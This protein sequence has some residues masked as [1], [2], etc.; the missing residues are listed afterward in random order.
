MQLRWSYAISI[1]KTTFKNSNSFLHRIVY[2]TVPLHSS[3]LH[4]CLEYTM[5]ASEYFNVS[6]TLRFRISRPHQPSSP[7][8][9]LLRLKDISSSLSI[10]DFNTSL[11]IRRT[12]PSRPL[13]L[14][15]LLF[16]H[17]S[18]IF[19]PAAMLPNPPAAYLRG[20]AT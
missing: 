14:N 19:I 7:T 18:L 16:P 17:L 5:F 8:N 9:V 2:S 4:C 20:S 3:C 1:P 6:Y 12:L 13:T 15:K 10:N 11:R